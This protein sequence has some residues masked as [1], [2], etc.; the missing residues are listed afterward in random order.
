[1]YVWTPMQNITTFINSEYCNFVFRKHRFER[2]YN[3]YSQQAGNR[4]H[5][6]LKIDQTML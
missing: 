1:M 2:T 6:T 3:A 4:W 5:M